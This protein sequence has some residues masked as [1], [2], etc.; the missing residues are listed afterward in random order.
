MLPIGGGCYN[1]CME[2]NENARRALVNAV[3]FLCLV[4]F[5]VLP[6]LK[7]YHDVAVLPG[8]DAQG[9]SI[10]VRVDHFYNA[11]ENI[12]DLFSSPVPTLLFVALFLLVASTLV[13]LVFDFFLP[14]KIKYAFF[15]LSFA[16]F[17]F[18]MV[19]ASSLARCY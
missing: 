12:R 8:F 9:N 13:F 7:I 1:E 19:A 18:L 14:S 11:F 3:L 2:R 5:C 17:L 10:T 4:A 16:M 15:S 6:F